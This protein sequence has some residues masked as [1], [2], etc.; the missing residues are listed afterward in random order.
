MTPEEFGLICKE[1]DESPDDAYWDDNH[2]IFQLAQDCDDLKRQLAGE[3]ELRTVICMEQIRDRLPCEIAK[4]VKDWPSAL[5]AV[6]RLKM[7]RNNSDHYLNKEKLNAEQLEKAALDLKAHIERLN[8]GIKLILDSIKPTD[9]PIDPKAWQ[10]VIDRLIDLPSKQSL[11]AHDREL[12]DKWIEYCAVAMG[13][14]P[15]FKNMDAIAE[16]I[17]N[18]KSGVER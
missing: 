18:L 8:L 5:T 1:Y 14:N 13:S 7:E 3:P 2:P 9:T 12:R 6:A 17:R 16:S 11:V 4:R 10:W 15:R